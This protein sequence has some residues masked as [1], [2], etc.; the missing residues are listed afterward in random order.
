MLDSKPFL[1]ATAIPYVNAQPHLGH[2]LLFSYGDVLARYFRQQGGEVVFSVGVDEH[3]NKIA[4]KAQSFDLEPQAFV[5]QMVGVYQ[6]ALKVLDISYT[7]FVRT[8][9]DSHCR[10]VQA[11]WR[12]LSDYIYIGLYKGWYC[13]GCE[14]YKTETVVKQTDGVCPDHRQPYQVLEE[15]N[16]FFKLTAFV[17]PLRKAIESDRLR[18]I[19]QAA[20]S[21]V[22]AM[23]KQD[24][25]DVSIARPRTSN[26]WG[27]E[28]PG[29]QDKIIYVWFDALLNYLTVVGYP[30]DSDWAQIWPADVQVIGR[31]ILRFHAIMWPAVLLA[32]KVPLYRQLYVHGLVTVE[33]Q[34]MSKTLGNSVDPLKLIDDYGLEAFRYY[35]FRHI[36]A[37]ENGNY[38]LNRLI[39][40]YNN[41]LVD[42]LGNL[43]HRLQNLI[44]QKLAGKLSRSA[45][46]SLSEESGS[47][48]YRQM[49]W[50][51]MNGRLSRSDQFSLARKTS[52]DFYHQMMA[53]CRFDQALNFIFAEIKVLNK[54]LETTKPWSLDDAEEIE[55]ILDQTTATLLK[56]L[57]LLQPFLPAL[58]QDLKKRLSADIISRPKTPPLQKIS[59]ENQ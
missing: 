32:L 57:D 56:L 25:Q 15:E 16:Y 59:F 5:D 23:L 43:V 14:D 58:A 55:P 33:G 6:E 2:A 39:E 4:E 27:I 40:V 42:Q 19:P 52:L 3:G 51:K 31:D 37:Y 18:I 10:R 53:D 20:K 30:D 12:K 47:D 48:A 50:H 11:A 13:L 28:V 41:E 34:K 17:N 38:S 49:I 9:D 1:V 26:D 21:E 46:F 45:Q 7:H 35:L 44:W 8:T 36:P 22:L 54:Y 24:V 29:D